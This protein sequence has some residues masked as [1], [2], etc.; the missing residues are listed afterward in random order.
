MPLVVRSVRFL[1]GERYRLLVDAE[2]GIP[3]FYPN[4]FATSQIR[5]GSLSVAAMETAL[6]GIKHFFAFCDE[7]A[8]EARIRGRQYF[9]PEELN[10]IRDHC[11]LTSEE[12]ESGSRIRAN[13]VLVLPGRQRMR[14]SK[15][16]QYSRM[17]TV[18]NYFE[19]LVAKIL[20]SGATREDREE[21]ARV[22]DG[23]RKR[24]PRY[25][26]QGQLDASDKALS[27]EARSLLRQV[28]EP[29][30]PL[31]PFRD[32]GTAERNYLIVKLAAD[33]G[34]RSGELLGIRISDID[35]R[36]FRLTVHRRADDAEDSRM[37]EPNAKTFARTLPVGKGLIQRITI[38]V[39]EVRS[40]VPNASRNEFLFVTH[41][42]GAT[43]GDPI[44]KETLKQVFRRLARVD[45]LLSDLHPHAL[46]HTWNDEFSKS[47][48]ALPPDKR[49]TEA[50]EEQMRDHLMGWKQ[51]SGS[52]ATYNKRHLDREASAASLRLQEK[53]NDKFN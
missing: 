53:M 4:L 22:A 49:P 17:S 23:L 19:W 44:S 3:L 7:A 50:Q 47:V 42:V 25:R 6:A 52:S 37:N 40:K 12:V 31:N 24:R 9:A 38:Y 30:H 8:L 1:G 29:A 35:F 14:V 33:L 43:Q 45:P 32:P 18:A 26:R 28:I 39:T 51:G 16:Y 46:R 5:N 41:K 11:R 20:G 15:A 13:G 10:A 21:A 36:Q 27:E 34:V 48:D 2:R